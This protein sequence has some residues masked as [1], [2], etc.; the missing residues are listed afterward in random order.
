ML[1]QRL[2]QLLAQVAK[3][4]EEPLLARLSHASAD[5]LVVE[6]AGIML[7]SR[8]GFYGSGSTEGGLSAPL[9]DLQCTLGEG[10]G[11]DAYRE[12]RAV[13]E[14]DLAHPRVPRWLAF[15]DAALD[16]G[17]R[18]VFGFPLHAGAAYFGALSL[19]CAHPRTLSDEQHDD[20]LLVAGIVG[21]AV[22]IAQAG[23]VNG[24][25]VGELA[26]SC[27]LRLVVHQA[28]GVT[29]AQLRIDVEEALLRLRAYAFAHERC[30][31]NVAAEVVAHGLRL[32]R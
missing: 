26:A 9:E 32:E 18:A 2:H 31:A 30:L 24:E 14:P 17:A 4:G 28:A 7:V 19:Y 3:A 27:N 11:V 29:A 10:P 1:D 20:A 8:D 16:V 5:V 25:L 13:L 23:A 15:A 12:H 21:H 22:L 6:A